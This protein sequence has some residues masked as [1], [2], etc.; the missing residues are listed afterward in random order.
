V[1]AFVM[2]VCCVIC[3]VV[4]RLHKDARDEARLAELND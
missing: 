2:C 4:K 3:W 1:W